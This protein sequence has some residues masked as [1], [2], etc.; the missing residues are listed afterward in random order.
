VGIHKLSNGGV[1]R[2]TALPSS[3]ARARFDAKH[4][5]RGSSPTICWV[6]VSEQEPVV[7]VCSQARR[8]SGETSFIEFVELAKVSDN[9]RV[10]GVVGRDQVTEHTKD[11]KASFNQRGCFLDEP[12]TLLD[13][14][15]GNWRL[16]IYFRLRRKA[17]RE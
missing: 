10:L 4:A 6:A 15:L 3:L 14:L 1:D 12:F 5:S 8:N 13:V 17:V 2:P 16:E 9:S 11:S 7:N